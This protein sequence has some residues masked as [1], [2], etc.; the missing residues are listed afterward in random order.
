MTTTATSGEVDEGAA[1]LGA[2]V[3]ERLRSQVLDGELA[4]GQALSVPR[5]AAQLDVSRS[6]VREAVQQ[7]IHDGLAVHVPFAGATVTTID[8]EGLRAL[9]RV[10]EVL[11]GLAAHEAA[12]LVS[13]DELDT[14]QEVLD[15]QRHSLTLPADEA[16]DSGLDLQF[17]RLV[18]AAARNAPLTQ[19]LER[20]EAIGHL[21]GSSMWQ[22]DLNRR[23]AVAEHAAILAAVEAGD[24]KRARECAEAHVAGLLVR[25]TRS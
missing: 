3:Y 12:G 21:H 23:V 5:L 25:M 20:L 2:S 16:R 19:A 1:L 6:P 8:A 11:D 17:H 14:M 18:R 7:L 13:L 10:R 15:R 24:A 9:F 22:L 4:P